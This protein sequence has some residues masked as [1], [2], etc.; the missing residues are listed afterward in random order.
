M[1]QHYE[2]AEGK[3]AWCSQGEH[4]VPY[5]LLLE[6]KLGSKICPRHGKQ[7]KLKLYETDKRAQQKQRM[8]AKNDV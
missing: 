6:N 7:V 4:W 5:A 2:T 3:Q 1:T 8:K